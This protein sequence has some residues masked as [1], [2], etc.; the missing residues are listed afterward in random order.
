MIN[1]KNTSVLGEDRIEKFPIRVVSNLSD[2]LQI[3]YSILVD[4]YSLNNDEYSYW[5]KVQNLSEQVGGLYDII[6]SSI[7]SNIYCVDDPNQ[8]VLGYFSVS[9]HSSRRIFIKEQFMGLVDLY[10]NC[11]DSQAPVGPPIPNLGV[12][13][14]IIGQ[15][16]PPDT[17]WILTYDKGCADC[18]VR[19]S[20][21]PPDFWPSGSK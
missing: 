17:Y 18:T 5:E 11:A 19:G 12:T 7:P 6:P 15:H 20:N 4:Q 3:E 10:V 2:R 13:V 21:T 16:G 8:K 14:W 9:G 1:I